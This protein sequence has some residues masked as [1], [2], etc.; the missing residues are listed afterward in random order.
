[1]RVVEPLRLLFAWREE[2]AEHLQIPL[3]LRPEPAIQLG[4][5]DDSLPLDRPLCVL[6]MKWNQ[7][8]IVIWLC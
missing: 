2:L 6:H 5:P 4:G 1:M 7:V 3:E 8:C